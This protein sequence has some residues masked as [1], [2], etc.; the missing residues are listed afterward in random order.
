MLFAVVSVAFA[1]PT[2]GRHSK[3]GYP[4]PA[5]LVHVISRGSRRAPGCD[6]AG[7]I[8]VVYTRAGCSL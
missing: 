5:V 1:V 6:L 7:S 4:I 2:D 8:V 3:G